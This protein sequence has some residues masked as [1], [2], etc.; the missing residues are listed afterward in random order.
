MK[1]SLKRKKGASQKYP[2]DHAFMHPVRDWLLGLGVAS[3]IFLGGVALIVYDFRVQLVLPPEITASTTAQVRYSDRDVE[4]YAK[5]FNDR[6]ARFQAL[7]A[8]AN[9]SAIPSAT[10]PQDE[11]TSSAGTT[12]L[13]P[14]STDGYTNPT[15]S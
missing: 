1:W 12:V 5:E 3:G 9:S 10:L 11:A 14:T 8:E 15:S 13:A 6:N 2:K 7:R 4:R